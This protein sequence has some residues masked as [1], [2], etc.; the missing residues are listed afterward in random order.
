MTGRDRSQ[1]WK[2]AKISG[3]KY[4]QT[5]AIE[6]NEGGN[7]D[8]QEFLESK[9]RSKLINADA[10]FGT[11]HLDSILSDKTTSKSDIV[12]EFESKHKLGISV[13]KSDSGQVWITSLDRFVD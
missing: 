8:L 10:S 4:E 6:L 7:S 13:K 12:T 9:A 5:L 1:G 11:A 2:H 3:H